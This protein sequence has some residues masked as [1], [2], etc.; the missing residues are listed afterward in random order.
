MIMLQRTQVSLFEDSINW[1]H[2]AVLILLGVLTYAA[3]CFLV[4]R[5]DVVREGVERE[6]PPP[7]PDIAAFGAVAI[8]DALI[9]FVTLRFT[10]FF[11]SIL[12]GGAIPLEQAPFIG[13]FSLIVFLLCS[14]IG[15]LF[16]SKGLLPTSFGRAALISTIKVS[17]QLVL[18]GILFLLLIVYAFLQAAR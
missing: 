1:L 14:F 17:I 16:I 4:R 3:A 8:T 10:T 9:R 7:N 5:S 2:F 12:Y 15:V 11:F 13:A 18:G 6:Y